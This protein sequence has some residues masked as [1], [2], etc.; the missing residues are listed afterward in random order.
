MSTVAST[1]YTVVLTA[2]IGKTIPAIAPAAVINSGLPSSSV[3][4]YMKAIAAG[5]SASA[6]AAID[7]IS[8]E[9][10]GG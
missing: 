8:P 1:I 4:G 5:G 3:V 7:G 6:L 10:F 9:Y 2:R